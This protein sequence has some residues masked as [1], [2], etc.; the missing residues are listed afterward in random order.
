M[1]LKLYALLKKNAIETIEREEDS[2][3]R[4]HALVP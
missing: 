2:N 1:V 4:G 3:L